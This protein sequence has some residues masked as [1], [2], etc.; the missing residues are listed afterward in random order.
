MKGF[1]WIYTVMIL[2]EIYL[3][4]KGTFDL[5]EFIIG[6]SLVGGIFNIIASE[7][8]HYTIM[9]TIENLDKDLKMLLVGQYLTMGDTIKEKI[10]NMKSPDE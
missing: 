3:Y 10:D 2:I 4:S 9:R 5:V 7:Y 6:V 8:S 1:K